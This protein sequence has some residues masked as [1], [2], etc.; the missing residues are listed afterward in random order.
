MYSRFRAFPSGL[1]FNGLPALEGVPKCLEV[2]CIVG[3]PQYAPT[4]RT[5][6]GAGDFTG[7]HD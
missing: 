5:W 3:T 7:K 6:M 1:N 2:A 4:F